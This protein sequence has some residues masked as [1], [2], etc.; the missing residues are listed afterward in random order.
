MCLCNFQ[1]EIKKTIVTTESFVGKCLM[2]RSNYTYLT[3]DI[4][5]PPF[6]GY[7]NIL[8]P[9]PGIFLQNLTCAKKNI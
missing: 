1:G 9:V 3:V 6:F 8:I 7:K 4:I 5:L 2:K